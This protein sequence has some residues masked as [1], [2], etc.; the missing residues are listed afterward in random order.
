MGA[1]Q[2]LKQQALNL[3][4]VCPCC[5]TELWLS[6]NISGCK[7]MYDKTHKF[8]LIKVF[9]VKPETVGDPALQLARLL[10]SQESPPGVETW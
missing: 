6:A 9:P 5:S 1:V 10:P 8:N 7:A 2:R 3:R 4:L